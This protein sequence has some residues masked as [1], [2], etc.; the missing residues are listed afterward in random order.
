VTESARYIREGQQK[1]LFSWMS[2][3]IVGLLSSLFS[4]GAA[5]AAPPEHPPLPNL[6]QGTLQ[7]ACGVATDSQGD[8][9]VSEQTSKK[10][11]IF[12]A[13]GS[14]ITFFTT[15]ADLPN[16]PCHIA[17][18]SSGDVYVV[19]SGRTQ[20]IKYVP[21]AYPPTAAATYAPDLTLNGNGRLAFGGNFD[22]SA[23]AAD[24]AT[25]D[26]YLAQDAGPEVQ[27]YAIP[28]ESYKLEFNAGITD[29]LTPLSSTTEI[30]D[31]LRLIAC[32]GAACVNVAA[33]T[34]ATRIRITFAGTLNNA[35]QPPVVVKPNIAASA[36][37]FE[38]FAG[39]AT[40]HVTKFA[41]SGAPV[42]KTIGAFIASAS[43]TGVGVYSKNGNV[44]L[45]D[46]A[47]KKAYVLNNAGD[48]ILAQFDGS[49]SLAG[50]FAFPALSLPDIAVDQSNGHAYV[51]DIAEHHV[52]D[53]FDGAGNFVS[54]ISH[55]PAFE[56]AAPSTVAV[57][58][59]ATS[60]NR[61]VVYLT[62]FLAGEE[63]TKAEVFAYGPLIYGLPL[64]VTKTGLGKGT[65]TSDPVGIDCGASCEAE[66][67]KDSTVTLSAQAATGSKFGAW[68]GCDAVNLND[69]CEVTMS[70]AREVSARF[71]SRP[72]VSEGAASQ[73]T[74]SSARLDAQVNPMGKETTY[75]FEYITEVAWLANGE[76][77]SGSEPAIQT[78]PL[79]EPPVKIGSGALPVPVGVKVENL[80]PS[81]TYRFRVVASNAAGTAEGER[82]PETDEEI[83]HSFTAYSPPDTFPEDNCS[84]DALRSGPSTKLPDCRAFEQASPVDKNGGNIQGSNLSTV[85]A[86][87]GTAISLESPVGIPG[88]SGAQTIPTYVARRGA[89]GWST[90]GLLPDPSSGQ[91]ARVLGWT[92]DFSTAFDQAELLSEGKSLLTRDIASGAQTEIFPHTLAA[93]YGYVG[94][95]KDG[96]TSIFEASD[97]NGTDLQLTP[98]AAA[99]KPNVYA[100]D[101]ETDEVVLAGVLPDG[102]TPPLGTQPATGEVNGGGYNYDMRT[103]SAEGS[104]FFIDRDDGQLYLRLNPTA[105]ETSA[106]D[107]KGNCVPD[108]TLACTVHISA[109][110][111]DN[112]KGPHGLDAAGPQ[113][114]SFASAS[115]D[116]SVI[117]FMS[118][119]KL[120]NDATTGP[121]PDAP[122]IARAKASDGSDKD[123]EFIPAFAREIAIDNVD[124]YV[125]WSD[126][127]NGR[128]GRAR[129]DGTEVNDSYLPDLGEPLGITVINEGTNKYI[130]WTDRGELDVDGKPQVGKG[131]IGRANLDGT[132]VKAD[133]LK[134]L[135]NPRSIAVD[136]NFIYWTM[137]GITSHEEFLRD[138]DVGRADLA[139]PV[140]VPPPLITSF[141]SGDI[142]VN[143]SHIYMSA[144]TAF[145]NGFI[146][147]F[148]LDGTG[149]EDV[150]S[151]P[152]VEAPFGLALDGTH[153]YW[154]DLD[155]N[156]IGRSDLAGSD[157]S[158]QPDFIS[159][160]R[161]GD[162][163][164]GG[165][166]LYWSGNQVVAPNPGTDLYQLDRESG[167]LTDLAPDTSV[168]NGVEVQG[169]LGA[170]EDG[171][172]VY[173]AA[174]GVPD[175]VGNSPNEEGE[176]AVSG[177]CKGSGDEAT[178]T[179]NLYV[180]HEGQVDFITRLDAKRP[181]AEESS[182]DALNWIARH[183]DAGKIDS[184]KT[185]RASADGRT[186]VFRSHR[187]LTKYDNEGP[188]CTKGSAAASQAAGPCLE[189][190][191]FEYGAMSLACVTCD[192][193]GSMPE[194]PARL[195][196]IQP[197]AIVGV[198]PA[199]MLGRN[200][201][202]DGNRFFFETPDALVAA[203]TNG[204]DGC[205]AWGSAPQKG[206]TRACQDVYEWE[207]PGTG[208]CKE[209]SSAYS[210]QNAGCIYLITTGKSKEA[211]F[212]GDADLDGEN[213]FVF[214]YEQLVGQDEDALL[215]AYD[216]RVDGGLSSQNEPPKPICENESCKA[217][218]STP[219]TPP[220]PG[221]AS[222]S[223]PGDPAPKRAHKKKK[224][225]RKQVQK[226]RKRAKQKQ[227]AAKRNGRAGR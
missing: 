5:Q 47:N 133:C 134:D 41:P 9:Y 216:A 27:E 21:S 12:A 13:D 159:A 37:A 182:G 50:A 167:K 136:P 67:E 196:S 69:E 199:D 164:R 111:K 45:A 32:G 130:F 86:E 55:D 147:R 215:D 7:R 132:D 94:T 107:A 191:R 120:T 152:D 201:S 77:F 220:P 160:T 23:V 127:L 96:A 62:A 51:T 42:S 168:P 49:D 98:D 180:A 129:L 157:P 224:K 225:K 25:D 194:G 34:P 28:S 200:L 31:K 177:D 124:G 101:R 155:H 179:C 217:P 143:S 128:I 162:P 219:S 142:A 113:S 79:D 211:S 148:K 140:S 3:A 84:T 106:T 53:E 204:E 83:E 74:D 89:D 174:N 16:N 171:S 66:F 126:P 85:A 110:K 141:A 18:D 218:P 192:P 99:G 116:G 165:E 44:Y 206:S 6:L 119:E 118:S 169:V 75:R 8:L 188:R 87:D 190:Y 151:I 189:F 213:V 10:V 11:S 35:D 36:P 146:R 33:G 72:L 2:V 93:Q 175:G 117:T 198:P 156:M 92:P 173:F 43:Y 68:G 17:V 40:D 103:V 14:P 221:S 137:P 57:D 30:R 64:K 163:A 172:Y 108:P 29:E 52:L 24:P 193:R 187:Q 102:S 19:N 185:A 149:Q 104:A 105:E 154:T 26:V 46:E 109:S 4:V 176:I 208:S 214:T 73:I 81:T 54:E 97:A 210:E 166:H 1:A 223:G 139:C 78:P 61:G 203:D 112:G 145:D 135:T 82:D 184:D 91:R 71:D 195:A 123:L 56:H 22:V 20:V 80:S 226:K 186:L 209:S 70:E 207:A 122:A 115:P 161:P 197:P 227:R 205:L 60:P 183:G 222:F 38:M 39:A 212:F 48:T 138:G 178:G 181:S 100:W 95:S 202:R 63:V 125:Y 76:S 15:T 144:T 153:L 121:E 158:E 114:A 90:K 150:V 65:V 59:S 58:G 170:S 88:G 131:T